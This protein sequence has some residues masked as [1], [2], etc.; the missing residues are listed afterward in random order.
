MHCIKIWMGVLFIRG[1]EG[2][3]SMDSK[4][5]SKQLLSHTVSDI[6]C[7]RK[8]QDLQKAMVL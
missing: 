7:H 8:K 5:T 6:I 2:G 1:R 4:D 3:V